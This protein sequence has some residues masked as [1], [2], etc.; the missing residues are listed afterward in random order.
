MRGDERRSLAELHFRFDFTG[1]AFGAL[2]G[3]ERMSLG[4]S[5]EEAFKIRESIM[6][7]LAVPRS[8]ER[9]EE[10]PTTL[11]IRVLKGSE[12]KGKVFVST[13][14]TI[15]AGRSEIHNIVLQDRSVSSNHFELRRTSRGLVLRDL[16]STNGT[17]SGDDL[18]RLPSPGNEGVLVFPAS[19]EQSGSRFWAGDVLLELAEEGHTLQSVSERTHLEGLVGA[20]STMQQLYAVL[21]RA[22]PSPLHMLV[23]GE[24]GTGKGLVAAALHKLSGRSGPFVV[25]GCGNLDRGTLQA[26]LLGFKKGAFTDAREDSPGCFEAADGGTVFI[27]E[28]GELPLDLQAAFLHVVENG[29]VTRIGEHHARPVNVRVIAATNR[30][31]RRDVADGRFRKDLYYRIAEWP[32]EVAPLRDHLEDLPALVDHFLRKLEAEGGIRR[33]LADDAVDMLKRQAWEGNVRQ[34]RTF[35]GQIAY[36]VEHEVITASAVRSHLRQT[37]A[38]GDSEETSLLDLPL[39]TARDALIA[40]FERD[41]CA[42]VL[43]RYKGDISAAA[44]HA[45]FSERGFLNLRKRCGLAE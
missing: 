28:V 44:K 40:N 18:L 22:A 20:S 12:D 26:K 42:A 16:G 15:T 38:P 27:D 21:E 34:L 9:G 6:G 31:L 11:V 41:Y 33:R 43:H 14:P 7:T 4:R 39:R 1:L 3:S 5:P 36:S 13:G 8:H 35:L 24:S 45:G 32:I 2:L 23:W 19:D 29:A 25:L 17:W 37:D 10:I 30:D